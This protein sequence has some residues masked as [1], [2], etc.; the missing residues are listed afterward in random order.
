MPGAGGRRLAAAAVSSWGLMQIISEHQ[1]LLRVE[2]AASFSSHFCPLQRH[3]HIWSANG[4]HP[5]T[6][7]PQVTGVGKR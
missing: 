5:G 1:T 6:T 7:L 3:F 2:D 4:T